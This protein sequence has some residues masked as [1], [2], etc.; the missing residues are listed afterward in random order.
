MA[1]ESSVTNIQNQTV[2]EDYDN[3][4]YH[5]GHLAPVLHARSQ[6]CSNATFTLTNAA[7][8]TCSFNK[9]QWRIT[10]RK[11][12]D[13]LAKKCKGNSAFIVTGVVP[14]YNEPPLKN[15]VI[16]PSHFWTAY[17]CLDN[18]LKEIDS[19]GFIGLNLNEP[20]K[21]T[22]V[23][24][25][26]KNLTSL[27]DQGTFHIFGGKCNESSSTAHSFSSGDDWRWSSLIPCQ[28]RKFRSRC[29]E[30]YRKTMRRRSKIFKAQRE[31]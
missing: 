28:K 7:P 13:H 15:R 1:P 26:E 11:V 9:G 23:S 31:T 22:S 4:G 20:V 18:N 24:N 10:E 29:A 27:Y 5:R 2:N 3:S 25:L 6:S 8:Q 14:G 21:Q 16:I 19:S 30:T 12:A 17:C